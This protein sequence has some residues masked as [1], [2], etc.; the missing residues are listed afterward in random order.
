MSNG[1][2]TVTSGAV[3]QTQ[4]MDVVA[5]NLA[6]I[7]TSAFKADGI[8]FAEVLSRAARKG[9][10]EGG[11]F[12]RTAAVQ[13]DLHPGMFQPTGNKLDIALEGP[14]YLCLK[15]EGGRE[16]Y[17]RGGTLTIRSDAL[18]A[19]S[20]GVPLLG[21]DGRTIPLELDAGERLTI[22]RDGSVFEGERAVAELKL[23]EFARPHL[24]SRLGGTHYSATAAAGADDASQTSVFQGQI[25]RS[26]V[27]PI[28]QISSMVLA[29]RTYQ[30]FHNILSTFKE[31]DQRTATTLGQV[32]Q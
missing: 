19:D 11:S 29:T 32:Q 2:Y 27:N 16:L 7:S 15:G 5:N 17:T 28:R 30:V 22:G 23:V 31:V 12:V 24:L 10:P 14:G 8:S 26:N 21:R 20:E 3:A 4:I 18:L 9:L 1:I 6:N 13:A 25:E